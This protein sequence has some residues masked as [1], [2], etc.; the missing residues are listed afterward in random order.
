MVV[1]I[2]AVLSVIFIEKINTVSATW[3][4]GNNLENAIV[5]CLNFDNEKDQKQFSLYMERK[6][7]YLTFL[8]LLNSML[9][10][11]I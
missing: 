6:A 2:P 3:Y 8:L 7:V 5:C 1:K 4:V 11:V 10:V 9:Y